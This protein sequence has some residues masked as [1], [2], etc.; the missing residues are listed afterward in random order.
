[1]KDA[2][3]KARAKNGYARRDVSNKQARSRV[4]QAT[5]KEIAA[6]A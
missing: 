5:R 3:K 4:K 2:F 6:A 1:M